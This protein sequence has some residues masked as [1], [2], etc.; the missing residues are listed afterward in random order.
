MSGKRPWM[1]DAYASEH[2]ESPVWTFVKRL[3]GRDKA[4]ALALITLLEEQGNA[5]RRPHSGAL[6]QGLFELRGKQ[7]RLF[8][9]FLPNRIAV[10]LDGEIKKQDA[11]PIAT[12]KRVRQYQAEVAKRR[13]PTRT[14]EKKR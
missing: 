9:M 6:G 2:G 12:L 11:I 1:V 3:E 13:L 5:V 8:Y 10:L 14:R 4:E 7:V